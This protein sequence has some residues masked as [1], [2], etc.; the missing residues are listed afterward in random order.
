MNFKPIYQHNLT[1][2]TSD[3]AK[4]FIFA[5]SNSTKKFFKFYEQYQN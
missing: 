5:L 2:K 1:K 4:R 3:F